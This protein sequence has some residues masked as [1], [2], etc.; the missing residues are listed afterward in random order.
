MAALEDPPVV[1]PPKPWYSSK[2]LWLQVLG[3][4]MIAVPSTSA[5]IQAN[6]VASGIAWAVINMILRLVTKGR[7]EIL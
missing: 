2:T 4:V 3:I 1:V 7:V 6:F 5:F